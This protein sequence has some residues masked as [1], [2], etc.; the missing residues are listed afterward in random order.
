MNYGQTHTHKLFD[1]Q[2]KKNDSQAYVFVKHFKKKYVEN[3]TE[4]D[5]NP[6]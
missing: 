2:H 5:T 1:Q 4:L 3:M 6:N